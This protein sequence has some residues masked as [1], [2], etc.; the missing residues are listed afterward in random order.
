MIAGRESGAWEIEKKAQFPICLANRTNR[1]LLEQ[2]RQ[3]CDR[4]GYTI[5]P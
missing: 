1:D 3:V 5:R 2:I 4:E